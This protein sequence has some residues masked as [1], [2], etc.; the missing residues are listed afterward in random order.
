MRWGSHRPFPIRRRPLERGKDREAPD[1]RREKGLSIARFVELWF[2][3][4]DA[5][6][7]S[8]VAGSLCGG[9]LRQG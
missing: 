5:T 9:V 3:G 4:A 2:H 1:I 8:D 7:R 6:I